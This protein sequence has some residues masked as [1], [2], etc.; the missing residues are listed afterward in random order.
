MGESWGKM[1][2]ILRTIFRNY[3]YKEFV[4]GFELE[5]NE[6]VLEFGC[7]EGRL[8][9]QIIKRL[10]EGGSLVCA[11]ISED[12]FNLLNKFIM[13][14]QNVNGLFGDIRKVQFSD[15]L[16]D[17]V[18]IHDIFFSIQKEE[19]ITY[20]NYLLSIMKPEGKMHIIENIKNGDASSTEIRSTMRKAELIEKDYKFEKAK[21]AVLYVGEYHRKT[22]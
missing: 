8:S 4:K 12:S 15:I 19:R 18:I 3:I 21:G 11:D 22:V 5:G 14:H 16:Y 2:K 17:R 9:K 6:A 7:K 10:K 1:K 20:V 13:K